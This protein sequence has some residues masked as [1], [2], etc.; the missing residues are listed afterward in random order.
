MLSCIFRVPPNHKSEVD[1]YTTKPLE[2]GREEGRGG[3]RGG[4]AASDKS[5]WAFKQTKSEPGKMFLNTGQFIQLDALAK[6]K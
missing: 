5:V 1:S 3:C 2:G 6:L 4:F